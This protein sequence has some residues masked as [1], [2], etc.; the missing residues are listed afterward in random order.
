M[1][2]ISPFNKEVERLFERIAKNGKAYT[3]NGKLT[4]ML[5]RK[6][7]D[8]FDK[9]D[10]LIEIY[11]NPSKKRSIIVPL[12]GV[13]V[14]PLPEPDSVSIKIRRKRKFQIYRL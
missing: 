10:G 5:P 2:K 1:K 8:I 3:N 4:Q 9:H 7:P 12:D 11:R 6:Y 14:I 13:H